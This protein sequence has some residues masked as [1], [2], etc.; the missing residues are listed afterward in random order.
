VSLL[1]F[2]PYMLA[3]LVCAGAGASV[4]HLIDAQDYAELDRS[5]SSYKALIAAD[6][7][8]RANK[9]V[10]E[11]NAQIDRIQELERASQEKSAS[12]ALVIADLHAKYDGM[13]I[14][15]RCPVHPS[16]PEA[17]HSAIGVGAGSAEVLPRADA[18]VAGTEFIQ[19]AA[20]A[21]RVRSQLI[22]CQA[23]VRSVQ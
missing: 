10:A 20:D 15:T 22:A 17:A 3:A 8:E 7:F 4:T 18:G 12:D 14:L 6:D 23:V 13:R 1:R 11:H 19:F 16:M 21:E 5:F 2:W 9:Q